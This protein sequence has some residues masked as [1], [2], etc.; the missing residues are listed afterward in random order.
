M[1]EVT[2]QELKSLFDSNVD[3]QLIDV[4][5]IFEHETAN[6][7]GK[8][9]PMGE[10]ENSVNEFDRHR[11][12]IVYCRSGARSGRAIQWLEQNHSFDNLYNLKGG[13][14]AWAEQIDNSISVEI[15]V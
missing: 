14:L 13:I 3:I 2:V 15:I 7:G 10:V 6:L 8:L 9:I 4:R 5:E 1:K 12:V 11:Q